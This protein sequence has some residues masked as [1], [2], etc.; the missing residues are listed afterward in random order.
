MSNVSGRG[1]AQ[2]VLWAAGTRLLDAALDDGVSLLDEILADIAS[3]VGADVA[4][5]ADYDRPSSTVTVRLGDPNGLLG[6]LPPIVD[7]SPSM[8]AALAAGPAIVRPADL[9]EAGALEERGWERARLMAALIDEHD[10]GLSGVVFVGFD[11][12]E[13]SD[14]DLDLMWGTGLLVR[15][16][17]RRA[18][19]ERQVAMRRVLD[20]LAVDVASGLQ[21]VDAENFGS[22]MEA[23][24]GRVLDALDA[25][26]AVVI[27]VVAS[28]AV[29]I[30]HIASRAGGWADLGRLPISPSIQN[31]LGL[32]LAA[33]SQ[34]SEPLVLDGTDL[35]A[36]LLGELLPEGIQHHEARTALLV[37]ASAGGAANTVLAVARDPA[38]RW[39]D[40]EIEV[41]TTVAAMIANTRAL[42]LAELDART[43]FLA[44]EALT[45]IGRRFV[46][47]A[48]ADA[49]EVA[50]LALHDLLATIGA[51][52]GAV[53][54]ET[55]RG[56]D[57]IRVW[58][59]SEARVPG[60]L[61]DGMAD[62]LRECSFDEARTFW[63]EPTAELRSAWGIECDG[64]WRVVWSPNARLKMAKLFAMPSGSTV[65]ISVVAEAAAVFGDLNGQLQRRALA[66]KQ[67]QRR[68]DSES[69]LSA[70][71]DDFLGG[72]A[73]T[74]AE[75]ELRALARIGEFL[76][77]DGIVVHVFDDQPRIGTVWRS[78]GAKG[79]G[80]ASGSPLPDPFGAALIDAGASGV[81]RLF[82]SLTPEQADVVRARWGVD[83]DPRVAPALIGGELIASVV[84]VG[85]E[86]WSEARLRI[87]RSLATMVGQ[88]HV[89]VRSEL[90]DDR[91]I[92][93]E[94]LLADFGAELAEASVETT[95]SVI[96]TT[97]GDI[98][99]TVGLD[100][101]SIWRVDH[102]LEH[103]R[104]SYAADPS[105]GEAEPTPF[106]GDRV[107][108][109]VR[110]TG[111]AEAWVETPPTEARP[112]VYAFPRAEGD[113]I[114][115]ASSTIAGP[116]QA[117][118]VD[119]LRSISDIV[120]DVE[121]RVAADR[122][123]DA[124]FNNSPIGIVLR[125]D[126]LRLI[127]CN[128]A[129]LRFVGVDEVD[130][131]VGTMPNAFYA[132]GIEDVDWIDD[133][134]ALSA[135]AA[136]TRRDG[137][138]VWG[139][140]RASVVEGDGRD[141]FWLVH[142]EDVTQ[143]R[144]AEALLRFQATHDELTGLANRGRLAQDIAELAKQGAGAAV[145]L[146]DLDRFKNINDSMGHDRGD[147]MLVAI[148]DRLRL[149]VR[150]GDQVARLGGDEFA[151]VLPGPVTVTDAEMVADRLLRLISEPIWIGSQTVYPTA[152]IGIAISDTPEVADLLRRADTAMYRAKAQGRAQHASFDEELAR[153]VTD[154]MATEAGLRGALRNEE[155]VVH[156]QPEVSTVDGT[157]LGAEALVRWDHPEQGVIPAAEFI[158][159]AEETGLVVELGAF[160]L[161][162]AVA[163]AMSWPGGD[164]APIVR[165]NLAAAQLQRDETVGLVRTVLAESGLPPH[166]LCLEI[167][168]SAVMTDIHRSEEILVRLK[169]LGVILAVDDF[170]TGFSS[171]AY[172]KRFPVDV[173]KIDRA[174]VTD[175]GEDEDDLAFV[176]SI[177]SLADAL[178]L[179]VVAEG[180]ETM[181]QAR[182]LA[183]LGCHRA[184]GYLYARPGPPTALRDH[185]LV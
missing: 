86:S 6:D 51:D 49:V 80:V 19:A 67:R 26:T 136:F 98:C 115:V 14:D 99:A 21:G 70:V 132:D 8:V 142:V 91:L 108:D 143:R 63:L 106:G 65:P 96:E 48:A 53:I 75:V 73:D 38:M 172:L 133:D 36:A 72:S 122:Y 184:Q 164:D 154:R 150:P 107:L 69:V 178:G 145:L 85:P 166:R 43:R 100:E 116:W 56:S 161:R 15:Q 58:E 114:L 105:A 22:A 95:R 170:G 182:I 141:F 79:P 173:L 23:T 46:N 111:D 4:V 92:R 124:A 148:A 55:D 181:T 120:R 71:A 175:L 163:E 174:F 61:G 29:E 13:W 128:D 139:Q 44:Q 185:L 1:I 35:K 17:E 176:R 45:E 50:D 18:V 125:D 151:V 11:A 135:E 24:L 88:F 109:Q 167:T 117:E 126:L 54:I 183:G 7:L 47:V 74:Q 118:T 78:A 20:R 52:F 82:D 131:I 137:A 57:T 5:I 121:Q 168:E 10:S 159:V 158:E 66:E 129:Y 39:S 60:L 180:V 113:S 162:Q 34:M 140:M 123:A 30:P 37:P 149:A 138:R 9:F 177:I 97:L 146:L 31:R 16:F 94:Q 104:L 134:G 130:E 110:L 112:T 33:L 12:P 156:Y 3:R 179:E 32:D 41:V 160:V 127:T 155:F 152:S 102:D 144:R 119:L 103:Y 81:V 40:D 165:V 42:C 76:D 169:E 157:M 171:L 28:D 89:R 147:E 93:T 64:P 77:L 84:A 59:G 25:Q 68:L 83:A 153:E 87:L 62:V 2:Q 101:L 90:R 27:D